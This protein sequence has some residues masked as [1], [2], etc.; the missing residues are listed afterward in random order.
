MRLGIA[1]IPESRKAQGLVL[2]MT[3]E[4]NVM[5]PAMR[6]VSRYGIFQR[7]RH[8]A[9]AVEI[10]ETVGVD[11]TLVDRP[12]GSLSG[13]NQQRVVLAKWLQRAPRIL[14]ADEPTRGVDI[15]ARRQVLEMLHEQARN[16]LSMVLA[17]SELEE[18][19]SF[20]DRV[21]VLARGQ[22]VAELPNDDRS[23]TVQD[24]LRATFRVEETAR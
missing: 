5:L 9:R 20:S 23:T 10:L 21:V 19:V 11:P 17:S 13:G 1:L 7:D 24:V 12:V 14:L 22:V 4:E 16:G 8:H 2:S 3:V 6:A 15:G 18:V